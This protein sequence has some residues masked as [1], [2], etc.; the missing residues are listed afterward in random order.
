MS[1]EQAR[2]LAHLLVMMAHHEAR[3]ET[4]MVETYALA[5]KAMRGN[6]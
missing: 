5:V 4:D 6:L 2:A 3:G 1:H